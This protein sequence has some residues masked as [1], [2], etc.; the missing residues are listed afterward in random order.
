MRQGDGVRLVGGEPFV[1]GIFSQGMGVENDFI[2]QHL[3]EP[4]QGLMVF[5]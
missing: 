5:R 2:R 4:A 3:F 1:V